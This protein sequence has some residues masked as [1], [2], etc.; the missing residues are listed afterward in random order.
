MKAWQKIQR[1]KRKRLFNMQMVIIY[2]LQGD[3]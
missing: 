3:K 2:Y 1:Y